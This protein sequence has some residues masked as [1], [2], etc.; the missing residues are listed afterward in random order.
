MHVMIVGIRGVP[1]MHGG[2]ETFAED[3]SLFLTARGHQVTVYCQT[4][5]ASVSTEDVWNGVRRVLIPSATHAVGTISYDWATTM[6]ASRREGVVLTLG[7]NTGMFSLAYRLRHLPN[8]M[9]MDGIEWRREKW[10]L[11]QRGWLWFNEWAGARLANH[12]VADHPEIAAHLR[13][14]TS[15]EKI[16][17]IPYGADS[18]TSAPVNVLEKYK[19]KPKGYYLLIA[20]AEPENSIL[21]IVRAFASRLVNTPLVVLGN[22]SP[23]R[24]QYQRQVLDAAGSKVHFVGAIYDRETVRGLR[25]HSKAYIHGHRVGGTNPSLVESLATGSA[26]IAHDNQFTRWVAGAGGKFFRGT[27]DLEDILSSLEKHPLQLLEMEESSRLRHKAEFVKERALSAY[28][29][30]LLRVSR[31]YN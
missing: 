11:P 23:E 18:V 24:S 9:N 26:I 1:A 4:D 6:H 19:L 3:L 22:Y 2:F 5:S 25:F 12:L 8:V 28:E 20:R 29:E 30:L 7:Y 21:E 14:H 10:S 13:R 16:T 17:M 15:A 31:C 27:E